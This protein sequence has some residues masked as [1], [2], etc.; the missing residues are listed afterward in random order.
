MENK[1]IL[2]INPGST[3]TKIGVFE[4]DQLVFEKNIHHNNEEI[5]Q[6]NTIEDQISFR[7]NIIFSVLKENNYDVNNLALIM[8]RGGLLKPVLSGVYHVN[9]TMLHDLK[10]APKFH[11]SN[12][13]GLIA[14]EIAEKQNIKAYI[15]DPVVVDEL[16]NLARFTGHPEFSRISI[17]HALNQKAVARKYAASI[18]KKYE[19]LNLIVTHIG[20]GITVGAHEKGKVID[21]NQGY[22][23]EGPFSP[24]RSGTVPSGDLI[25]KAFSGEYTEKE[26]HEMIVGKGGVS[27]YL[28]TNNMIEVENRVEAGDEKA[29]EVLEAMCYQIS[30]TIGSMAVALKGNVDAIL[31]TGGVA[32][33]DFVTAKIEEY[34]KFIAPNSVFPGE[35]ELEALAYNGSLILQNSIEINTYQ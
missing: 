25:K 22:D 31:I 33:S 16:S 21:V 13:A 2:V 30:K 34:T 18:D 9:E 15:A 32:H 5:E 14:N 29:T 6:L 10:H 1:G 20:G 12:L 3:S 8:A 19:D 26:M 27:A 24:E 17:F 7:K 23:G 35:D 28:G 11:A 4:N